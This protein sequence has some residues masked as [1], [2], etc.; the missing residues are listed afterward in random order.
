MPSVPRPAQALPALA[1]ATALVLAVTACGSGA[2]GGT[3]AGGRGRHVLLPDPVRH[4]ADHRRRC[5]GHGPHQARRRTAR[6]RAVAAGHRRHDQSAARRLRRRL[7]AGGRRGRGARRPGQG[8]RRR[9]CGPPDAHHRRGVRARGRDRRAARGPRPLG[10]PTPTSGS[11][12]RAMP[13]WPR[14]S[15]RAWRRTTPATPRPTRRTPPPS[16]RSCPSSTTRCAPASRCRRSSSSPATR[17]SATSPHATGSQQHGITGISPEAEP[18]A[19]ALKAV[20]DLVR[21]ERRDDDLPGDPRGAALRPDGGRVDGSEGR[22]ARPHRGHHLRVRRPGLLRGHAQ[23]PRPRCT[24][25][26]GCS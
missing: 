2:N 18:S 21:T 8:P 20:A 19:S 23:Q 11:T 16:S 13:P 12:P 25:G 7:P 26:Q 22:D 24:T 17:P 10:Q 14:P 5:P 6:P 9:R 15:V 3:S 1:A 4:A